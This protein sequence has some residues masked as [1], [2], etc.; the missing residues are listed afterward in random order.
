MNKQNIHDDNTLVTLAKNGNTSAFEKLI[1]KY[2]DSIFS[3]AYR[4]LQ[5]KEEAYDV[6]QET[7]LSAFKNL[8]RFK[9][10][11]SFST[12]IYRIALNFALMRKRKQKSLA[13]KMAV[14]PTDDETKIYDSV[15]SE[16][17]KNIQNVYDN[18]L[19][20]LEQQELIN[21]L[22]DSLNK[23]PEKYRTVF[24]LKELE[25]RPVEE[26]AKILNLSTSAIKTRLHRSRMYLK[27]LMGKYVTQGYV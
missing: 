27:E 10:K 24:I 3:L 4:I 5:D 13:K 14:I 17:V 7:A 21:I 11:S 2:E 12:W 25:G 19:K 16:E 18:P 6:L 23:L 26:I 9:G 20:N 8:K 15:E 1:K 22:N